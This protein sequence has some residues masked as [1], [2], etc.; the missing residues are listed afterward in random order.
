MIESKVDIYY[1]NKETGEKEKLKDCTLKKTF[2]YKRCDFI[3][4][5]K[6]HYFFI[7]YSDEK[8][9]LYNIWS[10]Y[11]IID[12]EMVND[13][14]ILSYFRKE[15]DKNDINIDLIKKFL[16]TPLKTSLLLNFDKRK[17]LPRATKK[18]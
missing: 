1:F 18:K 11:D 9:D 3:L 4:V 12:D 6:S 7:C 16:E 15:Y 5:E 13:N 10:R 8:K 14:Q 2:M 17:R